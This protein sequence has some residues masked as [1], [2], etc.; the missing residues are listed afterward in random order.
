MQHRPRTWIITLI[1]LFLIAFEIGFQPIRWMRSGGT[2]GVAVFEYNLGAPA[3]EGDEPDESALEKKLEELKE[4]VYTGGL[5]K[6]HVKDFRFV[7]PSDPSTLR[8]KTTVLNDQQKMEDREKVLAALKPG[9]ENVRATEVLTEEEAEEPLARLGPIGIFRPS[10]HVRLGLDLQGGAHVVLQCMPSTMM[11]F[12]TPDYWPMVGEA[13]EEPAAEEAD[14]DTEEAATEETDAEEAATEETDAEEAAAEDADL[15]EDDEGPT[16][17]ENWAPGETRESLEAALTQ[18]LN[19]M[20]A[21]HAE[22]SVV[23]DN[24]VVIQTRAPGKREADAQHDAVL[25]L[26]E[27]HC[28]E[29]AVF[30]YRLGE[31]AAEDDKGLDAHL[32]EMTAAMAKAGLARS[33]VKQ[34]EFVSPEQVLVATDAATQAQRDADRQIV[35]QVVEDKFKEPE[36]LGPVIAS[37]PSSVFLSQEEDTADKTKHIIDMRLYSMSD[38][39]EPIVQK[40]GDDRIIVELPGVRD[41]E[42]VTGILQSTAELEFRLV[43]EKYEPKD[44]E[45]DDYSEWINKQTRETVSEAAVLAESPVKFTGRDLKADSMVKQGQTGDWEVAFNL[46]E[47]RTRDFAQFTRNNVGRIMPIVLDGVTRMAPVIRSEIPGSGIISGNMSVE[48]AGDLKLL[49]NAGALPVPLE[50]VENRQVSPTLGADSIHQSMVAGLI[51]LALV[52][53]F[54]IFYYRLPGILANIALTLYI[55]LLIALLSTWSPLEATLTLPGIAGI[56]L[57]IGMAVDANIII[58]ERLKEELRARTTAR[59]A[60][61]AGFN[62]AWTAILD[63][64]VTTLMVAAALYFLGTSAIKSFAVTLFLGVIVSLFTAVTVSRWLVFMAARSRLGEKRWWFG[65]GPVQTSAPDAAGG[66]E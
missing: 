61:E 62:R 8:V 23:S 59:A 11:S 41:P 52:A 1:A 20:G 21:E 33:R 60:A 39:K 48:E 55:L 53:A 50:I 14:A 4:T 44:P 38:M 65:V 49:L 26:L 34:L 47:E 58:F 24:R 51:G 25:A 6:N 46:R 10:P 30:Q 42:R 40:Q 2:Q 36:A 35:L 29:A 12:G 9:F 37:E 27:K 57:S 66:S 19:G 17:A 16:T 15:D 13:E 5:D 56:I 63:A 32:S 28:A 3:V 43:P 22:V 54:M 7:D 18:L 31:P 45:N 64:N